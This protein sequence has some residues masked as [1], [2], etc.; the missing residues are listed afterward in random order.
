MNK[1]SNNP[2]PN[3][4]TKNNKHLLTAKY[5]RA[6]RK[7]PQPGSILK[8]RFLLIQHLASG[9][10]SDIFQAKDLLAASI[11]EHSS[12]IAIKIPRADAIS[13]VNL[14]YMMALHETKLARQLRH[15]NIV[16]I[17]DCDRDGGTFFITMEYFAG[18]PLVQRLLRS[19]QHNLSPREAFAITRTVATALAAIHDKGFVHSDVKPGN[20][21]LGCDGSIKLIDFSTARPDSANQQ[22]SAFDHRNYSGFSPAYAS[23]ELL[24]DAPAHPA[25]DVYSLACIAYEMLTGHHPFERLPATEA[26]QKG[27]HPPRRQPLSRQQWKTLRK[28]LEL[29]RKRRFQD[30]E[31][32]A[33]QLCGPARNRRRLLSVVALALALGTAIATHVSH[34]QDQQSE[35]LA[36]LR[37]AEQIDQVHIVAASI[38]AAPPTER[39]QALAQAE[40]LA[41]PFRSAA[42][43]LVAEDVAAAFHQRAEHERRMGET[44][45]LVEQLRRE[46]EELRRYYPA[47]S[48]IEK[49]SNAISSINQTYTTSK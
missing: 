45:N 11:D 8:G 26:M 42:L 13:Q 12:I 6:N 3:P 49:S 38:R 2:Q 46:L 5:Q 30:I 19:P 36:L 27:L 28:G 15:E 9:G 39:T 43:G 1:N 4:K 47:A 31:S 21:L 10:T 17:Y 33:T 34:L 32:F 20:I 40:R 23:P 41:E 48:Y 25:D 18:E 7:E 16:T 35:R 37:L 24:M 29:D 14:R 22:A 44:P